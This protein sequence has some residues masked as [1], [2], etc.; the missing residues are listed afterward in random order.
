MHVTQTPTSLRTPF[1][2]Q[3]PG[4]VGHTVGNADLATGRH[5][6]KMD[7]SRKVEQLSKGSG[8][9]KQETADG[10]PSSSGEGE[11]AEGAD[12]GPNQWGALMEL[13]KR[14]HLL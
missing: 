14:D 10:A 12:C 4:Q 13:W 9:G 2:L 3:V 11:R 1:V 6:G 8:V 5:E 7:S